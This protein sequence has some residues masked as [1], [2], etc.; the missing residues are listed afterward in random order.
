LMNRRRKDVG[1]FDHA[2]FGRGKI[3]LDLI[4]DVVDAEHGG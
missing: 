4:Q 1:L 3:R 2:D